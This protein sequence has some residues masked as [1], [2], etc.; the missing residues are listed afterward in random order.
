MAF[1]GD[2]YGD[3]VRL[4]K[5][6]QFSAELCGGTHTHTSA[7]VGPMIVLGESSI[8]SNIRRIEALTGESAYQHITEWR[9]SIDQ[10]AALLRAA[11]SEVAGRVR[12]LVDRLEEA[13]SHLDSY[14]QRDR[15]AAA[16]QLAEDAEQL[17]SARLVIQHVPSLNAEQLR[18]LA[19]AAR[20]RL[21]PGM[22]VLGSTIGGKGSL[23]AVASRDL[24]GQGISAA[25]VVMAG[26]KLL[27]GG[28]SRD[29]E[30]AQAG[31]PNGDKIDAALAAAHEAAAA[32]LSAV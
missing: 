16:T 23:V 24:V 4:V 31:G 2:K 32:A 13:E 26:A 5:I 7:Q 22:V 12:A 27:G 11:P 3:T 6:G 30:L 15:V 9:T 20:E 10:T 8:G 18:L 29:P 14:R 21:G 28:G 17:G 25:D 19:L 1:F